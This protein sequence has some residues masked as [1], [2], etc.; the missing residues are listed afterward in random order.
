[1][2]RNPRFLVCLAASCI[3]L[4]VTSLVLILGFV[5][6]F[7]VMCQ[8]T[9]DLTVIC[10]LLV[11]VQFV[12]GKQYPK[13]TKLCHFLQSSLTGLGTSFSAPSGAASAGFQHTGE[14]IIPCTTQ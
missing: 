5:N 7:Y 3:Y 4:Y 1:M 6:E 11:L 2:F 13:S 10:I 14:C 8:L 12:S 9:N